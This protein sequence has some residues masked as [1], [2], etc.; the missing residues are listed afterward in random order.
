M[1]FRARGY[2]IFEKKKGKIFH[3]QVCGLGFFSKMA[4][5]SHPDIWQRSCEGQIWQQNAGESGKDA[6]KKKI[7]ICCFSISLIISTTYQTYLGFNFLAKTH[8]NSICLNY[9]RKGEDYRRH[10]SPSPHLQSEPTASIIE[11]KKD[12]KRAKIKAKKD[13]KFFVF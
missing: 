2:L 4:P 6:W 3:W 7:V 8:V 12:K 5:L 13:I 1:P 10:Q 11:G 9:L